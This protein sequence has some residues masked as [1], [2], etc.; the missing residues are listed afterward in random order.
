MFVLGAIP[1]TVLEPGGERPFLGTLGCRPSHQKKQANWTKNWEL[2]R[3]T[4]SNIAFGAL[5][6][7]V[8]DE[9]DEP[10][11]HHTEP[12]RSDQRQC[13][14]ATLALEVHAAWNDR[15]QCPTLLSDP[16]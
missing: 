8:E 12:A 2:E 9:P 4:L 3:L 10:Q 11:S 7:V 6:T 15:R 1:K 5:E 14:L 16:P 13:L